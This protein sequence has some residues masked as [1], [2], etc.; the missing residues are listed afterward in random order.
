VGDISKRRVSDHR[1][2]LRNER[3]HNVYLLRRFFRREDERAV[4]HLV[5]LVFYPLFV[6]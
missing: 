1:G 2:D 4:G 3:K 6:E 5:S